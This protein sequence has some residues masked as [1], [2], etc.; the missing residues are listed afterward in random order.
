M[1]DVLIN[2][3]PA[4]IKAAVYEVRYHTEGM[5]PVAWEV[6]AFLLAAPHSTLPYDDLVLRFGKTAVNAHFGWFCKKVVKALGG[7]PQS[8]FP[9]VNK[10]LD[11]N[12]RPIFHLKKPVIQAM[13]T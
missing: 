1:S 10:S 2:S 8:T 5:S 6:F 7:T 9:L 4:A 13:A 3:T 12:K 11:K